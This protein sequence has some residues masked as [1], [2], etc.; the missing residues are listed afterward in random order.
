MQSSQFS[1]SVS[2]Q[3]TLPHL[4]RGH[5]D[6]RNHPTHYPPSLRQSRL[7]RGQ[8]QHRGPAS[9]AQGQRG[10][11]CSGAEESGCV[12][13]SAVRQRSS[14]GGESLLTV[15]AINCKNSISM[16]TKLLLKVK[17]TILAEPLKFDIQSWFDQNDESPCGTTACIA[18]HAIAI[19]RGW[20]K[21]K[22]GLGT[23][24]R[25]SAGNEGQRVLDLNGNQRYI[26]FN[27]EGWPIQYQNAYDRAKS[28][29]GKAQA[30][31]RR[32]DH[33]IKTKGHE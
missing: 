8:A 30:A 29:V 13:C 15:V 26:L 24:L 27:L 28:P 6:E 5:H 10:Q 12:E 19:S 23:I 4:N 14:T 25:Y 2:G 21:L 11:R 31:A 1:I 18:G 16:N 32:I 7:H 20:K 33:F 3:M 9:R 22:K 17:A